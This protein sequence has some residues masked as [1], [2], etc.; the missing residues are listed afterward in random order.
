VSAI[1][2]ALKKLEQDTAAKAG[3]PLRREAKRHNQ[4]RSK[5]V[6]APVLIGVA[7]S[8]LMGMGIAVLFQTPASVKT[9][10]KAQAPPITQKVS[11]PASGP[12]ARHLPVISQN[13][14]DPVDQEDVTGPGN[15]V[16]AQIKPVSPSPIID[17]SSN[18]ATSA[19][20]NHPADTDN[21]SD[22]I[23]RQS[24]LI[25]DSGKNIP[26]DE[27]GPGAG[28]VVPV[29]DDSSLKLQAISWSSDPAGRMAIINGKIC[30]EKDRVSGY[31]VKE[32]GS[33]DVVLAKGAVV[34]KLVFKIR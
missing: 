27:N 23:V 21:T 20:D 6:M 13:A 8:M 31:V 9:I 34:G 22:S 16:P 1:L 5:S 2:K 25:L 14:V 28:S 19:E 24:Q 33:G 15:V 18:D 4:L 32:I 12:V 3:V 26:A 29:L 11:G 17:A 10:Q 7:V 30:R